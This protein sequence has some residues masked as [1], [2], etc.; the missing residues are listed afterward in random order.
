MDAGLLAVRGTIWLSLIAW[1]I[2]EWRRTARGASGAS[3]RGAWTLGALAALVHTALAFHFHHGWSHAAAFADTA[4]QTAAVTGLRW[5]GGVY[6][7]YAFAAA[8]TGDVLWWWL[9]PRSFRH[10]PRWLDAAVRAF[11]WFMFVNGAFVFVRG[12]V[13]W[14]GAAAALA[15]VAA[16]YRGRGAE[17]VVDG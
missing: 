16:W 6:V 12:P 9:A 4:R 15:V 2:G 17:D 3:G 14:V 5:G 10:R 1:V 7:N 13:R 11:L 8:W